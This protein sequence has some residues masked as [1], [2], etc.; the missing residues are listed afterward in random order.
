[1]AE[2]SS[3]CHGLLLYGSFVLCYVFI[4]SLHLFPATLSP[5]LPLAS[6]ANVL[7][8]LV[9]LSISCPLYAGRW[10]VPLDERI[11]RRGSWPRLKVPVISRRLI[12]RRQQSTGF[13]EGGAGGRENK[14]GAKRLGWV[15]VDDESSWLSCCD[16]ITDLCRTR[17]LRVERSR[18]RVRLPSYEY[19]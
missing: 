10:I 17:W 5:A 15:P 16:A 13:R 1:M 19:M 8:C 12:N 2:R 6:L 18:R 11:Q 4:G 9:F 14:I 3:Q 7:F